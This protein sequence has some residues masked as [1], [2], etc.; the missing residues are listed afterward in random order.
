ML[1]EAGVA[2]TP[3]VDFD[4][5]RGSHMLRFSYAGAESEVRLG[6]DR[7]TAWLGVRASA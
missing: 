2:V 3:G 1:E 5:A 4:R 7:L 6:L